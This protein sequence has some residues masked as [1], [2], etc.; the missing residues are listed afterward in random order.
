[1][2]ENIWHNQNDNWFLYDGHY[3]IGHDFLNEF[4]QKKIKQNVFMS[5]DFGKKIQLNSI[6]TSY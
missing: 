3:V 5:E 6:I 1:M 4:N 2:P